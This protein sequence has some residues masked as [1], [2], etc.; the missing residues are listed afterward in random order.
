MPVKI[1]RTSALDVRN[2]QMRS[3]GSAIIVQS[4]PRTSYRSS[5]TRTSQGSYMGDDM[6]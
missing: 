4:N 5:T 1:P 3:I 6:S 2:P